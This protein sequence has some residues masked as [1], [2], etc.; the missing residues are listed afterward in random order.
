M[1]LFGINSDEEHYFI[2]QVI[3]QCHTLEFTNKTNYFGEPLIENATKKF[4]DMSQVENLEICIFY[5]TQQIRLESSFYNRM[6]V[7]SFM[8]KLIQLLKARQQKCA[9]GSSELNFW[10]FRLGVCL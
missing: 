8:P 2:L 3:H 6:K 5:Y 9:P 4:N 1:S 7:L 10:N